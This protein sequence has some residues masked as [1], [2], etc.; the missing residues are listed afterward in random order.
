M[1]LYANQLLGHLQ[2]ELSRCYL[3]VGD[4]PLQLQ[5]GIDQIRQK[6][7]QSGFT[8]KEVFHVDK[9]FSW[10]QLQSSA[11][12]M[13]LFAEKRM[14]ELFLPSGKPGRSGSAAITEFVENMPDDVMLLIRCDEWTA[15]NDKSKWVKTIE[16]H[17]VVMRVYLPRPQ[18][19]PRWLQQRC[20]DIG[21]QV[22][23]DVIRSLAL[24][25]EGN[26]L[27][28]AQELEKLKMRF[29]DTPLSAAQIGGLVADNARFDV[30]RLTD[31]LLEGH[32]KKAIRI[33]RSLRKNDLAPTIVL[34]ALHRET[35]MLVDLGSRRQLQHNLSAADYRR[36]GIWQNRQAG[37]QA[38]LNRLNIQR[39]ES[40]LADLATLDKYAK[41]RLQGDFWSATERWLGL[42]NQAV[43]V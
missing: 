24:R 35:S 9:S 10:Y 2:N 32:S 42:F 17:G 38:V 6:A 8:E 22:D 43:L 18:E 29:G 16:A 15:A 40:L 20:R 34:W 7:S 41:G 13:S 26:L 36:H 37:I 5:E 3:L 4:E 39:L 28:A 19:F 21:L 27:A 14:I 12:N 33:L 25:L 30:F 11:G 23:A 1:R 31:S